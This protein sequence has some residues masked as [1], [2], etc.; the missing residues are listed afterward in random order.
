MNYIWSRDDLARLCRH[1][2]AIIREWAIERLTLIYPEDAGEVALKL[3]SDNDKYA[4][5]TAVDYFSDYP[6]KRYSDD[7]LNLYKTTSGVIAGRIASALAKLNDTRLINAFKEKYAPG[8]DIDLLTYPLSI[9]HIASFDAKEAKEIARQS[10][11]SISDGN[12]FAL[13]ISATL[14]FANL[15][16]GTDISEL[17]NVCFEQPDNVDLI[18]KLLTEIGSY[19]GSWHSEDDYREE[20]NNDDMPTH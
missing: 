8:E 12:D 20:E 6:D 15:R 14:F 4:A 2:K 19:C 3:I 5:Q 11:K 18:I 17:L 16:A 1:R 13:S 9:L 10:L 7:L